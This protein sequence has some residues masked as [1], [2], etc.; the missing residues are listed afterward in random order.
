LRVWLKHAVREALRVEAAG[1]IAHH[2][3][4]DRTVR[5]VAIGLQVDEVE[6][7]EAERIDADHG[8][9]A[10]MWLRST[11]RVAV[12]REQSWRSVFSKTRTFPGD[13]SGLCFW[14][15]KSWC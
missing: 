4:V 15:S 14:F 6:E 12:A 9:D 2:G 5:R 7:I 13:K 1:G 11:Q 8:V 10:A 3:D